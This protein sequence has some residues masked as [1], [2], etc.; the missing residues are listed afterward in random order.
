MRKKLLAVTLCAAMVLSTTACGGNKTET[1]AAGSGSGA[2]SGSA[3]ASA[4]AGEGET[5]AV[6]GNAELI[7]IASEGLNTSID[8]EP[9]ELSLGCSGTVDGTVMGDAIDAAIEAAKTWTNGNFVVNFYPGGQ[10][11]GDVELIEGTQMGSVDMFTGAPTSQVGLIPELAVLDIGGLYTD[12][13]SANK[14]L[15]SFKEQLE[16]YY[17]NSGLHL[18]G[19]FAPDFRILTSNKPI[20]TAA[21][22]QGL[23]IRTQENKYHMQFWKELGTNP[24]PL[25]FGELY[26]ALQ[27]GM[28]DAEENPWASIVGAKLCEVQKYIVETNHIPFVSTYVVNK[29]KYDGMSDSQKLAF[30]QFVEFCSRYQMAGTADDDARM[31]QLC[32]TDY[33]IEVTPVSDEIKALY[34]GA[35]QAVI[36]TMKENI[37]PAFVDSY[38]EAA[39]A[40]AN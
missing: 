31:S 12:V 5:A 2:G 10:L 19:L 18:A 38:V 24:T 25:A 3:E 28:L 37:D 11:G 32:Q 29:A 22:L 16:P 20:K 7:A 17:N 35:S 8:C 6:G 39:K 40:A 34:E 30:N 36:A 4:A 21:D 1:A 23:N 14:V 33:G 27:Q 13:E 15:E 9:I 26:I